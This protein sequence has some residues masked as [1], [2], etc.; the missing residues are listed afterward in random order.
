[1]PSTI[2]IPNNVSA[3]E[4]I[5]SLWEMTIYWARSAYERMSLERVSELCLS[6]AASI[7]SRI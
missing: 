2:L 3:S 6:S 5:E 1:M 4:I 7:S